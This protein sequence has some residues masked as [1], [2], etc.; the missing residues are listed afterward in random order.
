MISDINIRTFILNTFSYAFVLPR[1]V[2]QEQN[3]GF[4]FERFSPISQSTVS[5]PTTDYDVTVIRLRSPALRY[6]FNSSVEC[7]LKIPFLK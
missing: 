1:K 5:H 2:F 4:I 7:I 6:L 3:I